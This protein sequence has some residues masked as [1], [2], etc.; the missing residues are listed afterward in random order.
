[1]AD[2]LWDVPQTNSAVLCCRQKHVSGGMGA[3]APDRSVH[4][5]VHQDVAR[6]ILLSYFD[7]LGIPGPH[8]DLTLMQP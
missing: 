1:M 5:S 2:L 7:D 3:Q 4:V 6:C 8:E